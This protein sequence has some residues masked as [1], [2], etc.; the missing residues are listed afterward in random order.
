MLTVFRFLGIILT[1]VAMSGAFAHLLSMTSKLAM[2]ETA[3]LAAQQAYQ[4]WDMLA[5]PTACAL[6]LTLVQAQLLRMR[7]KAIL[8]TGVAAVCM[9]LSLVV[10]FLFTFPA[11]Q[12]TDNWTVLPQGWETLRKQ[13]EYSHAAGAILWFTALCSLVLSA[14]LDR[15]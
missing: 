9:M 7:G 13:W 2:P 3:Y 15:D 6:V 14:L 1:A 11:N 12:A 5:I 10:F 4:R 8:L